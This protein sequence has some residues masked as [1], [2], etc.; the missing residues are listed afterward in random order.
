MNWIVKIIKFIGNLQKLIYVDLKMSC[1]ILISLFPLSGTTF[2]RSV[3]AL[4][5]I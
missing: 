4:G 2:Y 5:I 1:K 3:Q